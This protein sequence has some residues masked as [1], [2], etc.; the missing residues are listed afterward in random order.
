MALPASKALLTV[1]A[2]G[3]MTAPT[4]PLPAS[5]SLLAVDPSGNFTSGPVLAGAVTSSSSGIFSTTSASFVDVTNLSVTI[6]TS[7][8]PVLLTLQGDTS[9][10]SNINVGTTSTSAGGWLQLL[11][12]ATVVAVPLVESPNGTTIAYPPPFLAVDAPP[13]AGTYT[14]KVQA[15][16]LNATL[17]VINCVLVACE[18]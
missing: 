13:A 9:S 12:G 2:S 15:K 18:V 1:D 5:K 3:S 4:I 11:R 16:T 14:Y 8:G 7:G 17:N 10:T 6:T